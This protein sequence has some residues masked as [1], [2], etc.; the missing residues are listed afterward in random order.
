MNRIA[1]AIAVATLIA[2]FGIV[3]PGAPPAAAESNGTTTD[4][5]SGGAH[6]K[7]SDT[8]GSSAIH[9]SPRTTVRGNAYNAGLLWNP[10]AD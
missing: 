6:S 9:T 2:G 4:T 3:G 7:R 5:T 10:I 1:R 8:N